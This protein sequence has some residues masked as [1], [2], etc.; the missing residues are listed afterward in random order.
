[1]SRACFVNRLRGAGLFWFSASRLDPPPCIDRLLRPSLSSSITISSARGRT[2]P[3]AVSTACEERFVA[4]KI[5][6][7]FEAEN[8]AFFVRADLAR[9]GALPLFVPRV[10]QLLRR[11]SSRPLADA[12]TPIPTRKTDRTPVLGC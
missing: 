7:S 5:D 8:R 4:S 3:R 12:L 2:E 11:F 9:D 1:M 10:T 6:A